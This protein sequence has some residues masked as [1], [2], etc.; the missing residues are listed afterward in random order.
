MRGDQ[1]V[2]ISLCSAGLLLAPLSMSLEPA[3][4]LLA[5]LGVFIGSLAPDA[6][7]RDAAIFHTRVHGVKGVK[8]QILNAFAVVL[9]IFGYTIRYL[10]YYPLS[11]LTMIVFRK[12]Y[13]HQHRGLLHSFAGTAVM[14]LLLLAYLRAGLTL[15][16]LQQDA[17]L[18]LFGLSFLGG[19][20]LHLLEDSCTP[21]G[22][23]WLFPASRRRISGRIQATGRFDP[24]PKGF[25]AVLAAG[26]AAVFALQYAACLQL[27]G[28]ILAVAAFILLW[29]AFLATARV[30]W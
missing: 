12:I 9:P 6:D 4:I 13:S 19:C 1:H 3:V 5:L 21:G 22:V 15:A 25:A 26:G 10:I 24:R 8:G 2:A 29:I 17:A 14:T 30:Q 28:I 11:L 16:G 27:E 23:A 7:A 18:A 20:L